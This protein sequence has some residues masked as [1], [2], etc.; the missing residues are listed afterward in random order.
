MCRISYAWQWLTPTCRLS[1]LLGPWR[2]PEPTS[3]IRLRQMPKAQ[4]EM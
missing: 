3:S 4:A 2:D 1:G